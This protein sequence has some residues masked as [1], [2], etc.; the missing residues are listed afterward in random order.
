MV[1]K[2]MGELIEFL[3]RKDIAD[4]PTNRNLTGRDREI[5]AEK[6]IKDSLKNLHQSKYP[7]LK[8]LLLKY[9]LTSTVLERRA[10]RNY[11]KTRF[12]IDAV[13]SPIDVYKDIKE[14]I[15]AYSNVYELLSDE[16]SKEVFIAVQM[17]RMTRDF[18]YISWAFDAETKQYFAPE[19]NL[20]NGEIVVDCGAYIGDNLLDF[21]EEKIIPRKYFLFEPNEKNYAKLLKNVEKAR[22]LG[23]ETIPYKAGVFS[24]NTKLYFANAADSSHITDNA[25]N[26]SIDVVA[27]DK[28]IKEPISFIK[29]DIEGAELEALEGAK[30]LIIAYKP[31]LAI[32]L[33]HKQSD[34]YKIPLFIKQL[35]PEYK[36]SIS[37]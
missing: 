22:Q 16:R 9:P 8:A 28:I 26:N 31:K 32:C 11:C 20:N 14:N 35:C 5:F 21:I 1:I 4:I 36:I 18:K 13:L 3:S 7:Q 23:I 2:T 15:Q 6:Y 34:F 27:L 12:A 19:L 24:K 33:Y 17:Y 10:Y 37:L 30:N 25:T 29:M